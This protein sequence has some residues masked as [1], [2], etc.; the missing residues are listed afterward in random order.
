MEERYNLL[1]DQLEDLEKAKK[2]ISEMIEKINK[3]SEDMFIKTFNQIKANFQKT[4]K[5]LFNGGNADI[6]LTD[7]ENIL[8]TG[9]DIIAHPPGQKTQSITL[10]SGGQR[11]MT[12]I[13][14]M[15]AAFFVKPSPFCLLDEIDAALDEQNIRRFVNLLTENKELSQFVIITHNNNTI[16]AADV[17]YGVTQEEKGVSKIVSA[18]FAQKTS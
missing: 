7:P 17:M 14:L 12:A 5:K 6:E 9:V 3:V 13:A 4:F 11:T 10:L 16:S 1:I 2:D 15:F 8:E 18:K